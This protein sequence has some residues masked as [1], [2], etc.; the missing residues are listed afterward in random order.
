LKA[1]VSLKEERRFASVRG[2]LR[3]Q[4]LS[5]VCEEARCPN[6]GECWSSGTATFMILGDVCTR[7]CGFCAVATGRPDPPDPG[8]PERVAEAAAR[9]RLSHVVVTSVDRDDLA[10]GGA[11]FFAETVRHIREKCPGAAIEILIPDFKADPG[12]LAAV[13]ASRPDVLN[14]NIETV[15]RLTPF[16]RPQG[17]YDRSLSVVRQAASAG[18]AA[19]S[20]IMV[21][22][23]ET[24]AEIEETLNDLAAAGCRIV[25]VGQYLQ[26]SRKS[27]PVTRF[28]V[29]DEFA[30]ISRLG[31]AMGID[32]V[33]AGPLV[34]SSYHAARQVEGESVNG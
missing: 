9:M 28:Y 19:K 25:T 6:Q 4:G 30:E 14:H 18:L 33:S 13:F 3:Q 2:I 26:P 27:L 34:R 5:T 16:V 21:G 1:R 15:R 11:S 31:R 20:G 24:R 12:A 23:G 7:S 29:S 32:R 10:D 17:K 22:L 8:E